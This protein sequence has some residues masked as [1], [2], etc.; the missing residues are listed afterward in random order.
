MAR[1]LPS[2][3]PGKNATDIAL[4]IDVTEML[5]SRRLQTFVLI[6]SDTDFTPLAVRIREEGKDVIW[7]GSRSTPD[8]FR[9]RAPRFIRSMSLGL[10][11]RLRR[12]GASR[13]MTPSPG[14]CPSLV[15]SSGP[16]N[17]LS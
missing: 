4:T 14:C 17:P 6:A 10:S 1:H 9:R 12:S 13:R 3:A 5:I 8:S 11:L 2:V 15:S 7:F 16:L